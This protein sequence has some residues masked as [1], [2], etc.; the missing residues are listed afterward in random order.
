M[1]DIRASPSKLILILGGSYGGISTA[2]YVLK[3]VIPNL[4]DKSEYQVVLVSTS[5]QV[6]C[7]PACPRALI[8]DDLLPQNKL[9]VNISEQFKR[10]PTHAFHFV[11]GTAIKLDHTNRSVSIRLFDET[12]TVLSFHALVIA[13]GASTPSP[14]HGLNKSNEATLRDSWA[15]FREALP[16]A[17]HIII[18]GGGPT[19]IETAGELGEYLN[20]RAG[21]F[22]PRLAN[23]NVAITV[24]TSGSQILPALRQSLATKAEKYLAQLGVTVIKNN[25]VE[26]VEPPNAG[27]EEALASKATLT[28]AD[29]KTLQ[30]DLYIPATGTRPNI[31]F[32][33]EVLLKDGRV[34]TNLSTL[35]VDKAGV[36]IYAI[37]DV[38]SYEQPTVHGIFGAVPILAGNLKRD[39]IGT[40]ED[41]VFKEDLRETQFVPIG[42]SKGVGAVMG[43]Q[44]PS[45][46][47]WLI[48][49]RDYALWTT[50]RLW[51]GEQWSKES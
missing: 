25:R 45:Y 28:L 41:R 15:V 38:A 49:G 46:L 18:A 26:A 24:V 30:A 20:G 2:H 1:A 27:T 8:S 35:R 33:D 48:K 22:N 5:S 12:Q 16:A 36:R 3:H 42:Q 29:G 43:Y 39:L 23:P 32:I 19:A 4:Q 50:G 14:L 10:Y 6:I 11:H 37:G 51:N 21:W 7:R 47:V 9:F 17:K 34:E 44:L 13:T 31:D 40:G